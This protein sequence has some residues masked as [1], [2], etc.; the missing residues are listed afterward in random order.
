MRPTS[1]RTPSGA[2]TTESRRSRVPTASP[3]VG[4]G[5]VPRK[6]RRKAGASNIRLVRELAAEL[7]ALEL[8]PF[9]D[10][11]GAFAPAVALERR[12]RQVGAEDLEKRAQLIQADVFGR[13]GKHTA[14]GQLIREINQWAVEHKHQYLQARSHRL[15][16]MFFDS[17]GDAPSAWQHALRAVELIDESMSDGMRAE[18]LFGLGMAL[19]RTGAFDDARSRYRSALRLAERTNGVALRLKILN[20]IAWLEDDAGDAVRAIENAQR[21]G[22]FAAEHGVVMDAACLDT[23]AHAQLVLGKYAE[24]E[25]TLRPILDDP[26]L[27]SRPSEGLAEALNTAATAQRLQGKLE[28]AQA[29]LDQCLRLC[30]DRGLGLTRLEALEEQATLFGSQGLFERAYQQHIA[31]HEADVALRAAERE[32]NSR[33]LHAV[34]ETEEARYEGERFREMA[35]RDALTGLRNRRYVDNELPA[36]VSDAIANGGSLV[37]GL[38]DVDQFKLVND[39]YSHATGDLVLC[40]LA[41]ILTA[42]TARSG[43]TARMGGE[44]F[45]MVCTGADAAERFEELRRRVESYPWSRIAPALSVTI[46][47][48][49]T[50]VR[51]GRL[52]QAALLGQ[53]DRYLYAAKSAGRNRMVLDPE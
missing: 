35:L 32:A 21:M 16:A 39:N 37:V 10:A 26:N 50:R 13:I 2:A 12:A 30:E 41:E 15:L 11:K 25:Q 18:H 22:S 29:T 24:A 14:S 51:P 20:N 7:D 19:Q 8:L 4:D 5:K 33:T 38:L 6:P 52:T 53:A 44:E 27:D 9:S 49:A 48:G 28:R 45:L 43:L 23:I 34:F 36:I 3:T 1:R 31:F 17:L 47:I 42:A 40:K 46:S